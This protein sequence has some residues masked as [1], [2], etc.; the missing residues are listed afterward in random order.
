M[1][2]RR[3]GGSGSRKKADGKSGSKR[4]AKT[5]RRKTPA[6]RPVRRGPIGYLRAF[7]AWIIR[8]VWGMT[9]RLSL[10]ILL[11]IGIAVAYN[12]SQL[13]PLEA[14]LDGR[15]R[16]SVTMLDNE[17]QVFA[18]RGDQFGGVVT[19]DT[20]SPH[21]R[22]AIV[23][24]E[25]KRFYR[26]FGISPRGI[27][28]AIRINL[29]EGRGPLSGHGGSTITQQTAKLLCLGDPYDPDLWESE[30]AY[31]ADCRETTLWRK[32]REAIYAMG[33]EATYTKDEI[34]TIYMNRAFLGAGARGF[35]AAS[36][37]Y[38]GKSA[39][40]VNAAEAAMLAGLL[41][42]PTRY[43]P[44]ADLARSQNRAAVIVAL[45]EEQGYLSEQ[46][47]RT[48]LENPAELSEAAEAE[49]GGY[50]ADWVMSSGPEFL[51]RKTTED[52]VIRTTLDQRIQRA[53]EEGMKSVFETKVKEGSKAQAAVVVMSAD[54]AVRAM[55]GGRRT[56]VSGVFNRAT[57]A[58]RQ[59]GSA[60][61]PFVYATALELGYH[62]YDTVEDTPLTIDI[63]GSG[64]WSPENYD[65][66]FRGTVTLGQALQH[67]LNIP[68]VK[69][70]QNVGLDRVRRIASD[71]GIESDL[72]EGPAL[73][74]GASE[75]TLIEMTGA[76]AG[77][78]NG[79][80]SVIPYGLVELRLQGQSE[81]LMDATGGIGE[82][83]IRE[84]AAR[85]LIWMMHNVV[86][87][88]T[89]G[90]AG[91]PDR[92]AAG[93]TGTTSAARDAWFVGFTADYVAGV[94]MGYDDNTPLTGVTGSGLP[95]EIWH[96]VMARVHEG[97]PPRDLPMA[98]PEPEPEPRVAED[99]RQRTQPAR[100]DPI[101]QLLRNIFGIRN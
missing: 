81:P 47:A 86:T 92:Q 53:A 46:E 95:A 41:V 85:E 22:N 78:L 79:G 29:R 74:L 62:W 21:L 4:T 34:L 33:L 97:L 56:Q 87:Q 5:S 14:Q 17:G 23:A 27:A 48:A 32:I 39:A 16:G 80:S 55:V 100:P 68:A 69:V 57:Q 50:F 83:V 76:Y 101:G 8:L 51:T 30:A 72:A 7:L 73:A 59:T 45:M 54:G 44:T 3:H 10:V 70:A 20:V 67:S 37:R 96:E 94:W 60:F 9:W 18:W 71:F 91:L 11:I 40:D 12:A 66:R 42:A 82:R 65:R 98:R 64:P 31:E 93:K 63:P 19:T 49:A 99:N 38:F 6:K 35:E 24:T 13:P 1:A 15:A 61:K 89:G 25:D 77:I 36:Q 2:D 58:R 26:H 90:R 88:G 43:A 28:S 84:S 75:S 52:V